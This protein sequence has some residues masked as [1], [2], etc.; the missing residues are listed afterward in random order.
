MTTLTLGPC[1]ADKSRCSPD[2]RRAVDRMYHLLGR[3]KNGIV[4]V[5]VQSIE[6]ALTCACGSVIPEKPWIL[7]RLRMRCDERMFKSVCSTCRDDAA[8]AADLRERARRSQSPP[9]SR[10]DI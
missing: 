7:Q 4:K 6:E 8:E 9:P 10:V 1:V 5:H 3:H 2:D